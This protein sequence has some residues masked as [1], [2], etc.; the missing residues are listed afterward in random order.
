M[1]LADEVLADHVQRYIPGESFST[2][3]R[4]N[5][6]LG[7]AHLYFTSSMIEMLRFVFRD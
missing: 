1:L 3:S 7:A 6:C 5:E 4:R 2:A